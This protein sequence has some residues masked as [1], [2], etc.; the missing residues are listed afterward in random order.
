MPA[1]RILGSGWTRGVTCWPFPISSGWWW[2]ITSMFPTRTSCRKTTHA[3]GCYGAW[4]GWAVSVSVLPLTKLIGILSHRIT[5]CLLLPPPPPCFPPNVYY[6][7]DENYA[8]LIIFSESV[9]CCVWGFCFRNEFAWTQ[10]E[11]WL[12]CK[13]AA[14]DISALYFASQCYVCQCSPPW[15]AHLGWPCTPWLIVSLSYTR[16]WSTWS[17]WL[18]F[19]DWGFCCEGHGIEVLAS[20]V[21]PLIDEDKT[22]SLCKLLDGR[23]W[24]WGKVGLAPLGRAVLCRSLIQFSAEGW[25]CAP[26]L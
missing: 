14:T 11:N 12:S 8:L 26:S 19:C 1:R 25:G 2:L 3:N 10:A 9:F 7:L 5:F 22:R 15:P 16:L 18:V 6:I 20:S 17:F 4:P 21:C 13:H 24:L 23:P